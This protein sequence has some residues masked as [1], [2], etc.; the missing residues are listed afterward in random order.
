MAVMSCN[1]NLDELDLS[2]NNL[3]SIGA[4][5][6]AKGLKYTVTLKNLNLS[7]NMI[8]D[9]AANDIAN[10]VSC[11]TKL[12]VL[13]CL[14]LASAMQIATKINNSLTLKSL[15]LLTT[16]LPDQWP[17]ISQVFFLPVLS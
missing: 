5:K 7:G 1:T 8:T 13:N 10:V 12:E 11:N 2:Y 3:Q 16:L 15:T 17:L 4:I 6:F 9:E 14:Q